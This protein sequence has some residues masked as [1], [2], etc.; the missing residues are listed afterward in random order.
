MSEAE[1]QS[2]TVTDI[3][4]TARHVS[5]EVGVPVDNVTIGMS[6]YRKASPED[7]T[8]A[9]WY[10]AVVVMV[11]SR[12]SGKNGRYEAFGDSIDLGGLRQASQ[13]VIESVQD[14]RKRGL[15]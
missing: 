9:G 12:I 2:V 13:K 1:N 7:T 8:P 5:S 3:Q 11:P 10:W 15:S 14:T 6:H 4:E